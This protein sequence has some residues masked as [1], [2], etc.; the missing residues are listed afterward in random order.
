MIQGP[1]NLLTLGLTHYYF[2]GFQ[3]LQKLVKR[4]KEKRGSVK[5]A[6]IRNVETHKTHGPGAN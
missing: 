1:D 4:K 5:Y 2:H 6:E 3:E